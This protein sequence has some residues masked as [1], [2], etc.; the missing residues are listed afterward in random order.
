MPLNSSFVS[1]GVLTNSTVN[2]SETICITQD[3]DISNDL[4]DE[5]LASIGNVIV[6]IVSVVSILSNSFSLRIISKCRKTSFQ[7]RYLSLN[8]LACYIV[9]ESSVT[10]H[11]LA[12]QII[13]DTQYWKVFN[14]RIF[15]SAVLVLTS[16][17]C[18]CAVSFERALALTMPFRY[19]RYLTKFR[20][21]LAIVSFWCLSLT[22]PI[23]TFVISFVTKCSTGID[24]NKLLHCDIYAIWKP[25]RMYCMGLL[26]AY[27]TII[28]VSS[29]QILRIM[30]HHTCKTSAQNQ[31]NRDPVNASTRQKYFSSTRNVMLVIFAFIVLQSPPFLFHIIAFDHIPQLKTPTWRLILQ[32]MDYTAHTMNTYVTLYI[33]IWKRRECRM[34][35]YLILSRLNKKYLANANSLRLKVYDIYLSEMNIA[36]C[37]NA[38]TGKQLEGIPPNDTLVP[39]TLNNATNI[40][41]S[42]EKQT[43]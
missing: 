21:K 36:K 39:Q 22:I 4:P 20:L 8:F 34:Q 16:W 6:P 37:S 15:V 14:S 17:G 1:T 11:T 30:Y 27:A 38:S 24:F 18:I 29:I 19:V 42:R 10:A 5:R 12:F 43:N 23:A 33:Y 28:I 32:Y 41:D 40:D 2:I 9:F 25:L 13:D 26:T 35:I 31:D 3:Y 7:I